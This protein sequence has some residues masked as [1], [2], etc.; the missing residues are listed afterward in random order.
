MAKPKFTAAAEE[1]ASNNKV[2]FYVCLFISFSYIQKL[3]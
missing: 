2:G 1:L 3:F